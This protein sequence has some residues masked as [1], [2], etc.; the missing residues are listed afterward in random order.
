MHLAEVLRIE[1]NAELAL[2][3]QKPEA[4]EEAKE[5][6]P[7]VEPVDTSLLMQR[8][9]EWLT[10]KGNNFTM[11]QLKDHF[12]DVSDFADFI[13]MVEAEYTLVC[14]GDYYEAFLSSELEKRE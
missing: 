12:K 13:L 1:S 14:M 10:S 5:T 4:V 3:E 7:V 8:V 11:E 2:I 6:T 9:R